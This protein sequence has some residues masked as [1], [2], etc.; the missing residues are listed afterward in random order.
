MILGKS[1]AQLLPF[2]KDYVEY[3]ELS[4]ITT[5]AQARQADDLEKNIKRLTK[6]KEAWKIVVGTELVPVLDDVVKVLLKMQT[7][8]N[9]TLDAAKKYSADG[10]IKA[11]AQG[12]VIALAYVIDFFLGIKAVLVTVS[13]AIKAFVMGNIQA[14]GGIA[15]TVIA[16]IEGK[17]ASIPGIVKDT[18]ATVST[19]VKTAGA[20]ISNEW[21]GTRM[22]ERMKAQFAESNAA[23]VDGAE[24]SK[25]AI[26]GLG[27]EAKEATDEADKLAKALVALSQKT[28]Q[29]N[30]EIQADAA[31]EQLAAIEGMFKRFGGE[32][33]ANAITALQSKALDDFEA[34]TKTKMASLLVDIQKFAEAARAAQP[35]GGAEER[36]QQN[37]IAETAKFLD[38]QKEL[39]SVVNKR[40]ESARAAADREREMMVELSRG[41]EGVR[42]SAEDYAES[43]KEAGFA[44]DLELRSIGLSSQEQER[45]NI[46]AKAEVTIRG[47][48]LQ[49]WRLQIAAT[50]EMTDNQRQI[51]A[52]D[53]KTLQ[54]R[55]AGVGV[56]KE[57]LIVYADTKRAKEEELSL[58][59]S[60]SDASTNFFADL[61]TNGKSAFGNLWKTIKKFFIDLAAQFATKFVLN[62][63]MNM[64]GSGGGAGG[65]AASLLSGGGGAGG[66]GSVV[67]GVTSLFSGGLAT[68]GGVFSSV[69]A[70]TGSVLQGLTAG[71]SALTG[72]ATAFLGVLGPIGLAV[73]AIALIASAFKRDNGFKVDNNLTNVGNSP[74]HFT[75]SAIAKFDISGRGTDSPEMQAAFK[76]FVTA[77]QMI[78]DLL[79]NKLLG[80]DVL[81][82]I[83]ANMNA[84][85]NASSW[86]NL[87]KAGIEKGT[88]NFL[89]Q[90]YGVIFDEVDAKIAATVRGFTGTS[91]ELL[92]FIGSVVTVMEAIKA[93][94]EYFKAVIGE[95]VSVS[96]LAAAAK[97]G[98]TLT[99]TL[100]RVV[101]V[102]SATNGVAALMGKDVTTAFSA[103][104]MASLEARQHI[105]DLAGGIQALDAMSKSY[106]E[107]YFSDAER[108]ALA[109]KSQNEAIANT[110]EALGLSIPTTLKGFRDLIE[111]QDLTTSAGRAT[112]VA[113]LKVEGAF[114][115][116][117]N[118]VE[119]TTEALTEL[120]AANFFTTPGMSDPYTRSL[121]AGRTFQ[122]RSDKGPARVA[123]DPRLAQL[124]M[125]DGASPALMALLNGSGGRDLRA[126]KPEAVN[127]A[128]FDA[129]RR[130]MENVSSMVMRLTAQQ[131]N[132]TLAAFNSQR[133]SFQDL[134]NIAPRSAGALASVTQGMYAMRD[135]TVALLMQIQEVKA[136]IGTMFGDTI[137]S[138]KLSTMSKEEQYTFYQ[139]DA[140]EARLLSL[141]VT[142]PLE[143]KRQAERVNRDVLAAQ[144]LLTPE[145]Q[146]HTNPEQIANLEKYNAQVQEWLDKQAKAA[147]TASDLFLEKLDAKFKSITDAQG[148][149]S[150][151]NS[152]AADKQL[153]AATTTR[154]FEVD[155]SANI[156]GVVRTSEVGG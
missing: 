28:I 69:L 1:G 111:S 123:V 119:K 86:E 49:L 113:L 130:N 106:Y 91:D 60:I 84:V 155:F 4:V 26:R 31:K 77:V 38:L 45:L 93:N 149:I 27:K 144:G 57:A 146:A 128:L 48:T 96:Q 98:E 56:E 140:E 151:R 35:G 2:M 117:N 112:S 9:G 74:N 6:A 61:F 95:A 59:K 152:D 13:A 71:L 82:K 50:Y 141:S 121:G 81:A 153:V 115:A 19:T 124:G 89:K 10:S 58:W 139:K 51:N 99:Q 29:I 142:D 64:T 44:R 39:A 62:A 46:A 97:E 79:A 43:V 125:Y 16:F 138:L 3:G 101:T 8:T 22:A 53:Q 108:A 136:S 63:V 11:W 80:A 40:A 54:A 73:G 75:N 25:K 102:F 55:I 116:V 67:S 150:K 52:L 33:L 110:F 107:H 14:L 114:F 32:D 76:P 120:A 17:Y 100:T 87:D 88:A 92:K 36:A 65:I 94:A 66:I 132:S 37:L 131:S 154:R 78:D 143:I 34:N 41:L 147:T 137:R 127:Q 72:G 85:N 83:R 90:R 18:L 30:F 156:P 47:L 129:G 122:S 70:G 148:D 109:L 104:G 12:A 5:A 20:D 23:I 135:A 24:K 126:T 68:A 42:N 21:S 134:M 7:E 105:V 145:Q 133:A 103:V 15:S 118:V